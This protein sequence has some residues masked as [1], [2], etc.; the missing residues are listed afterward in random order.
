MFVDVRLLGPLQVVDRSGQS[1]EIPG[2]L[3]KAL[4]A[5]LAL[6]APT[7]VSSD[8]IV[9]ALWGEEP[10]DSPEASLH[11]TVSR[12]RHALGKDIIKRLADSYLLEIPVANSDL[13]R[14]RRHV[15]RGVQFRT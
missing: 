8:R 10:P 3:P 5:I 12:L 14:F 4:L 6:E 2:E 9:D 13:A 7:P 15:Q 11:S 1:I